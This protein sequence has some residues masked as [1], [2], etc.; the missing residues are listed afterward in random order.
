MI[1]RHLLDHLEKR[2]GKVNRVY[3]DHLDNPT[4][5]VGHLL[6][7]DELE[8]YDVGDFIDDET[9]YRWLEQ[10][11]AKAWLAAE[12]QSKGLDCPELQEALFSVN[13]QLGPGWNTKF[14]KTW[15]YLKLRQ[16]DKAA[17]EVTDSLWFK[18]TPIRCLDF[19]A[20]ILSVESPNSIKD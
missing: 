7:D 14:R 20:A 2:E 16:Y 15:T 10:D 9:I 3:L 8:I 19:V 13:Y 11:T 6:T 1:P 4:G 18:Q 12:N 17:V 5:G